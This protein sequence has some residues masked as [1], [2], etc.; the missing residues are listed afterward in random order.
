M[1]SVIAILFTI[2]F[3]TSFSQD[4]ITKYYKGESIVSKDSATRYSVEYFDT[5]TNR[6]YK[7][8]YDIENNTLCKRAY[9]INDSTIDG[10]LVIYTKD[11]KVFDSCFMKMGRASGINYFYYPSG[12]LASIVD[13]KEDTSLYVECY[14]ENGKSKQCEKRIEVLPEFPGGNE[15]FMYYL[16]SNIIYPKDA[17]RKGIEGKVVLKFYIDIDGSVKDATII[18]SVYPS[19]DAESLRLINKMPDWKPG[20]QYGRKIKVYYTLPITFRL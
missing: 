8:F 6:I 11:K 1:K 2:L 7:E 3:C 4:K 9:Y 17:R 16:K 20:S 12:L 19:I 5:S 10:L 18:K 15:A 14:D 13:F